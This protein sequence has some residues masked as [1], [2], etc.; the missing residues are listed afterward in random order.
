MGDARYRTPRKDA[1]AGAVLGHNEEA[2][3][4]GRAAPRGDHGGFGGVHRML[5]DMAADPQRALEEVR[6]L[7]RLIRECLDMAQEI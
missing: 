6:M 4:S 7:R 2:P 3:N 1:P 5:D